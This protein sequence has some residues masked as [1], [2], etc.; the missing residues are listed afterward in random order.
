MAKKKQAKETKKN[1]EVKKS[2]PVVHPKHDKKKILFHGAVLHLLAYVV[3][4]LFLSLMGVSLY[5]IIPVI[6]V[7][8]WGFFV[9]AYFYYYHK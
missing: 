6:M 3:I 2:I 4:G 9:M 8:A 7:M 5:L 1:S